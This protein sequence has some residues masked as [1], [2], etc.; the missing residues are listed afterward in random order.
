MGQRS[1]VLDTDGPT[2]KFLYAI[3][4]QLD[5]KTIDW[6]RVATELGVSN[7]HAARMRYSRF[8]S[9][10]DG[11]SPRSI[12]RKNAKKSGKGEKGEA[13]PAK[14]KRSS[15]MMPSVP[16]DLLPKAEPMELSI[17]P[18]HFNFNPFVK[19]E[20]GSQ[21]PTEPQPLSENT[22]GSYPGLSQ[23]MPPHCIHMP[24]QP[25]QYVSSGIPFPLTSGSSP[26]MSLS[27]VSP[28]QSIYNPFHMPQE[29]SMQDFHS[30]LSASPS[31]TQ[32]CTWDAT[33]QLGRESI[34]IPVKIKDEPD[35]HGSCVIQIERTQEINS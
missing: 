6:N 24:A 27:S 7:G 1:K 34:P 28:F 26:S 29:I 25:F 13:T 12:K 19:Y 20:P 35:N 30:Q 32:A 21:P 16:P 4:K 15:S 11:P 31:N 5:L 14:G 3:I 33:T 18:S 17:S 2:P 10:M 23:M 22:E 9:Q 8:R